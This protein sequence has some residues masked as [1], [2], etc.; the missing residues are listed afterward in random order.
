MRMFCERGFQPRPATAGQSV[1]GV[2]R[3]TQ[4]VKGCERVDNAGIASVGD[5]VGAGS[6][7]HRAGSD[8]CA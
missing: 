5:E 1:A 4:R 8:A 2:L 3:F 6:P 7:S